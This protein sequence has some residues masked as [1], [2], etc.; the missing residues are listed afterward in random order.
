MTSNTQ[1]NIG[2]RA[3]DLFDTNAG[4]R[5]N[6]PSSDPTGQ[7]ILGTGIKSGSGTGDGSSQQQYDQ[8]STGQY[9]SARSREEGTEQKQYGLGEGGTGTG[10]GHH[11]AHQEGHLHRHGSDEAAKANCESC[12]RDKSAGRTQVGQDSGIGAGTPLKLRPS[13]DE[14]TGT[15][16][17]PTGCNTGVQTGY[18]GDTTGHRDDVLTTGSNT[19]TQDEHHGHHRHH[20]RDDGYGTGVKPNTMDKV[21]GGMEKAAGKLTSD[22][23][24][25]QRG[26]RRATGETAAQ[27]N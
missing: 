25:Y 14:Q 20:Q 17:G 21:I 6:D 23:E 2:D 1:D 18:L 15:G 27:K 16:A 11:N 26:E 13:P 19:G 4:L 22:T 24:L 10:L 5:D 8:G 7:D 12:T 9:D 3:R